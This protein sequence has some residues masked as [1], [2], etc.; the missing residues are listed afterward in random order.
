MVF[1]SKH[2]LDH[3]LL[4]F[5]PKPKELCN[6]EPTLARYSTSQVT[7]MRCGSIKEWVREYVNSA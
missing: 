3:V 2:K 5:A 7:S 6:L 4:G 1:F